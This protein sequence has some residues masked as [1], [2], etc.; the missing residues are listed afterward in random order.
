MEGFT[1]GQLAK[2]AGVNVQTVRYYERRG[3]MPEPRRRWSGYRQYSES[4]VERILFIKHAKELGFTLKEVSELLSLRVEQN[5][6]CREVKTRATAKIAEIEE[7]IRA[8][9]RMKLA[10]TKIADR[11]RGKGPI[12]EC[13]ILEALNEISPNGHF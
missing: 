12:S 13:P 5:T 4:D 11:C 6:T 10:L 3:L 7:K 9:E 1:I 2:K 8:L